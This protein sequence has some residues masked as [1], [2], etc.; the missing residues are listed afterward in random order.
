[1][2]DDLDAI[3]DGASALGVLPDAYLHLSAL[4]EDPRTN[5][6]RIAALIGCFGH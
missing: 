1:M 6:E 2:T 5:A 3:L 4:L